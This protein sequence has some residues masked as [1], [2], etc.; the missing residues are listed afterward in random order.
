MKSVNFATRLVGDVVYL[1]SVVMK[2]KLSIIAAFAAALC[3]CNGNIDQQA[4][5]DGIIP[6][7]REVEALDGRFRLS[8]ASFEC[9]AALGEEAAARVS[10]F[11][12]RTGSR[13]GAKRVVSFSKD[14]SLPSEG[15]TIDV[16]ENGVKVAAADYN[17]V[18]YAIQTIKQMLPSSIYGKATTREKFLLPCCHISDSPRF[19]YRGMHLDVCR[20]FFGVEDVKKYIDI[21][22][23]Y[24]VNRLHWHLTEDQGWRLPIAK[25]PKLTEVGAWR[26][27][28]QIG[29]DR[30]TCDGIR[31]GGFYTREEIADIVAYAAKNGITIVPEV[32]LPGHMQAALASYPELGCKGSQPLPYEVWTRWG[33]SKQVLCVGREETMRFLEDV[34][35]EVCEMFP[36]EYIHIGGDECPKNEWKVDP[37]CQALIRKMGLRDDETATKEDRLQNYVTARIQAFLATKGRKV[38]GWDEVLKG[39]L[40]PGA[41][42]M[43]WRG[44]KGGIQAAS[45]GYDVIMTPSTYCYFDYGQSDDFEKEPLGISNRNHK[46]V[47]LETVYGYEP[48]DELSDAAKPFIKGVQANMWTEY[49]ATPEHLEYMLLPRLAAISEVQ[50]CPEGTKDFERLLSALRT[51]HFPIYD[52]LG[53][54]YRNCLDK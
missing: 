13:A 6:A 27:G 11:A 24:K 37:D 23:V 48:Y 49:I 45:M 8:G 19:A 15:Y 41:T 26:K 40:A 17:G 36:S 39:E 12:E 46:V 22:A 30:S 54:N 5:L 38:I 32:D 25:Y 3:G 44:T 34:L 14:A 47:S 42:V 18:L 51:R 4:V 7:P 50:W 1:S 29:L 9:D 31:Y 33:V 43:S 10:E 28:T 16:A 52:I 35:S 53:Y 21:I 2:L 20:H